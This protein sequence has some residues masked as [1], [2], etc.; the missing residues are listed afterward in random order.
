[1]VASASAAM[2]DLLA[3]FG[4]PYNV[5]EFTIIVLLA[6]IA[7]LLFRG[8]AAPAAVPPPPQAQPQP[9]PSARPAAPAPVAAPAPAPAPAAVAPEAIPAHLPALIAAAVHMA[10]EGQAHRILRIEP[11]SG[12]WARE[13]RRDIFT[14]HR[15][16]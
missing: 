12:N 15:I 1:M 4:L 7:V 13:G 5:Q 8:K 3:V 14:S 9:K 6:V 10:L 16:R 11:A 2:P